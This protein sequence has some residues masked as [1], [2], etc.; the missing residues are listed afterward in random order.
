[1]ASETTAAQAGAVGVLR[2]DPMA[3]LPFCGYHVGDYFSHWLSMGRKL[4]HPPR[5]FHVNW[6][7]QGADGKFL[8]PGYGENIRVLRWIL[9]RASGNGQAV[10]TPVGF[11]P[12]SDAL[13]LDG[14]H[15]TRE[16]MR[17]LL[18]V[19][20]VGWLEE[21]QGIASFFGTLGGRL[22]REL[23][24]ELESLRARLSR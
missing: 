4:K 3:M 16:A 1:M 6:F 11:V 13:N 10:E 22:P 5:I 2:R 8:W 17:D 15:V 23:S 19:D 24:G 14:T 21:V 9:E 18:Y 20:R 12:A 7:R